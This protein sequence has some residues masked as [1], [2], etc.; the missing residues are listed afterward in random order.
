[1]AITITDKGMAYAV[2]AEAETV[3]AQAA[4]AAT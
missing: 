1:M 4:E 3:T 2:V